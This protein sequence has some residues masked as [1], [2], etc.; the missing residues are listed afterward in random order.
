MA[1]Q[2]L[3]GRP[4]DRARSPDLVQSLPGALRAGA[5]PAQA[6]QQPR[7]LSGAHSPDGNPRRRG[8]R[9]REHHARRNSSA[10]GGSRP[11]S[12]RS[13]VA[14]AGSG[15]HPASSASAA[16]NPSGSRWNAFRA[17]TMSVS[18]SSPGCGMRK[19][20]GG[21]K[22]SPIRR[23]ASTSS[24]TNWQERANQPKPCRHCDRAKLGR[25]SAASRV[26]GRCPT[27]QNNLPKR[28]PVGS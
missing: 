4:G 10:R 26:V 11:N 16:T 25:R 15:R 1:D 23:L 2:H 13:S 18:T 5:K 28:G 24:N 27:L 7:E 12:C 19:T 21:G 8:G 20:A 14:A 9:S 17:P 3:R 22:L 6:T